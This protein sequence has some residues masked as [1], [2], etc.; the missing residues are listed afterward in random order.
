MTL[1]SLITNLRT[2]LGDTAVLTEP[3]DCARYLTDWTGE[4][5]GQALAVLRPASTAD[6]A[7]AVRL[8][9]A[10][11]VAITPQGG[12]TSVAGGSVPLGN[13]PQV[14]LSLDRLRQ[15]RQIDPAARSVT[16]ES[17]C[18]L[19]HLQ[20]TIAPH[21][22]IYPLM[23]GARGSC[24]IGGTLSTNA[25]GSNVL[26]YGN[27]RALCVGIEA[28]MADGS[29]V[30]DLSGLRKDNTGYDLRD[31][32]IGAEGTLG[33]IT[34]A[35]LRLFP[36]PVAR[37]TAFLALRDVAAA[38][39]VLNR[40][41]DASGGLVE[42]FE[43]MPAPMMQQ[44]CTHH[45]RRGPFAVPAETGILLEL[46]ST[47][48]DD[49]AP[50]ADGTPRLQALVTGV[51]AE[52]MEEGLV[53][54]AVIATSDAQR[55]AFWALREGAAEAI[56]ALGGSYMF[57]IAL[58]LAAVPDFVTETDADCRRLGFE[59]L[60]VA[61]LGDGNLH[62]TLTAAQGQDW[63]KLPVEAEVTRILDR[64]AALGGS[65]SAEHGI[66]QAKLA[67]MP[68]YRD[69]SRLAAMRAIKD[70]LDPAGLLNPGKTIPEV[71]GTE[72]LVH[73]KRTA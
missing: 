32:M 35:C 25:G 8:C 51:L 36:A 47:R 49:A 54:D 9:A 17:G 6:V 5:S 33:I 29:V 56:Y 62:Y 23:F 34:A 64:V 44:I 20:E 40:L 2:A 3:A 13:R 55:G 63:T 26:R 19:Q 18:V 66:G 48:P 58:P 71:A 59:V 52:L 61:H 10:A 69:A 22:L 1:S 38:L 31:L 11:G 70:A 45:A 43:Y 21:G 72:A 73:G 57:D 24:T 27:A 15:I 67:Y 65:F 4:F 46:A 12:N 68:L 50:D 37:A 30:T 42:A 53:E 16:V 28:V 7:A 39:T 60:T 14:L 41:Q